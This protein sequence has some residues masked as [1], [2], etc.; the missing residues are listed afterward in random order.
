MYRMMAARSDYQGFN[1][2]RTVM[3]RFGRGSN[4]K[5]GTLP[6]FSKNVIF[7]EEVTD[8]LRPLHRNG[9]GRLRRVS[10]RK[11]TC[12]FCCPC[13]FRDTASHLKAVFRSAGKKSRKPVPLWNSTTPSASLQTRICR[14]A[15]LSKST[16]LRAFTKSKGVTPYLISAKY[17]Y[18]G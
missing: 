1:I 11:N 3:L 7:D 5:A 17:S 16:L 9:D 6:V 8:Y 15:G 2:S 13:C 4:W 18:W 12:F 14:Y 10:A